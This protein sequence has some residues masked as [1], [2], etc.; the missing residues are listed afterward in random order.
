MNHCGVFPLQEARPMLISHLS[1]SN[2][3]IAFCN[4]R[5]IFDTVTNEV[6]VQ[7]FRVD[8]AIP[9]GITPSS[10]KNIHRKIV[11]VRQ[12]VCVHLSRLTLS[13][14][15]DSGP[16]SSCSAP[17]LLR[18]SPMVIRPCIANVSE[19]QLRD[20]SWVLNVCIPKWL[21]LGHWWINLTR[22]QGFPRGIFW[23]LK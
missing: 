18:L 4:E 6:C 8:I 23:V 12:Q 3:H 11:R 19:T 20:A 1:I 15:R 13:E 14:A 5:T 9:A 2:A 7:V 10:W 22:S 17:V 16:C 21:V